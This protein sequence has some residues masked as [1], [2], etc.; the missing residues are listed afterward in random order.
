MK[1]KKGQQRGP[2]A[3]LFRLFHRLPR[4]L[5][6]ICNYAVKPNHKVK[7]PTA[8]SVPGMSL[9]TL[10]AEFCTLPLPSA[11]S[12]TTVTYFCN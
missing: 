10:W 11:E 6:G 9:T 4:C 1:K 3:L 8:V 12:E 7:N 2:P 5:C